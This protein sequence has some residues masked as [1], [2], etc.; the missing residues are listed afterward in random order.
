[1]LPLFDLLPLAAEAATGGEAS[2]YGLFTAAAG[3]S[4]LTLTVL[5]IVLGIDNVVFIAILTGK[6]PQSQRKKAWVVGLGLAMLMRIALLFAATWVM[7]LDK[8]PIFTLPEFGFIA[9]YAETHPEALSITWKDVILLVGG[10]FLIG[11]ATYEIHDKLEGGHAHG[12]SAKGR[13]G[14]SFA[15]IITQIVLLDIVFS[16]DSVI[17]AVGIAQHIE[18]MITAVVIAI[19]VMFVFAQPISKFVERHPSMKLLALSFLILIGVLLVADAFA[20]HVPRGYIYFAMA[21]SVIVEVVNIQIRKKS[22]KPPVKLHQ[23]YVDSGSEDG[24]GDVA[25]PAA[26]APSGI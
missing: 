21:F 10:L 20:V 11:K 5:E 26:P 9:S 4:L 17:T 14:A 16:V 2:E 18:V 22:G 8:N 23:S 12:D 3:V 15:K 7:A 6:L 13:P 25:N 19:V 1:M 24:Y